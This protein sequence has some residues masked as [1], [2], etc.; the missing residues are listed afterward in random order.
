M[1][2]SKISWFFEGV[3]SSKIVFDLLYDKVEWINIKE[4]KAENILNMV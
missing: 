4:I 1:V 3:K 2:I